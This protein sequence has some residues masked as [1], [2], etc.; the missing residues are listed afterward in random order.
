MSNDVTSMSYESALAAACRLFNSN[1]VEAFTL[2]GP[3]GCGKT[4]MSVEIAPRISLPNIW[5][6]KAAHH[7]VYDFAGVPVAIHDIKRT[8][9]YPSGDMLPPENVPHLMVIDEIGDC[10]V[11]QQ[12]LVC[13]MI[14][15]KRLHNYVFAPGTKF[16]LT[17][18][19][20]SDRSGA[21]NI[22]TKLGNRCATATLAPTSDEL[23]NYGVRHGW[24]PIILA[25]IKRHGPERINPSDKR[26]DAPTYFNSFDPSDKFQLM[27]PVFASSRSYEFAS[28]YLNYV[29]QHEAH[30]PEGTVMSELA[31]MISHTVA[32]KLSAFRKI[33]VEMPDPELILQG[34]DVPYPKKQEVMWSLT[35]SLASR[36]T[37][38][39]VG[40]IHKFLEQG[41]D[42][43]LALGARIIFDS[44]INEVAGPEF[45]K[46]VQSKRLKA[47][48]SAV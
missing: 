19:R 34:K 11:Q 4:S 43:F 23:F 42:E 3:P 46:I 1:A 27:N 41:P 2:K 44:R 22:V 20:L 14:F 36:A 21:G 5:M 48:F 17:T 24:N 47:M 10:N 7:E 29:D 45:D 32:L 18:N 39:N 15:E 26:E 40:N 6:I 35:I 9:M 38:K 16:F 28:R 31:T 13:Q 33:A 30:L 25:F 37:K 12:N 8:L